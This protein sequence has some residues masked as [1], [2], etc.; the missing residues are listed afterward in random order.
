MTV[1]AARQGYIVAAVVVAFF[2]GI[3]TTAVDSSLSLC[4]GHEL[5]HK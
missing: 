4:I 5:C 1:L 2:G 3:P